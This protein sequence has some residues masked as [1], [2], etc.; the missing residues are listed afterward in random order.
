MFRVNKP[1]AKG[2]SGMTQFGRALAE[3]NIEILCANSSQA[4]GRVE[5]ANRTLQ[6]RL[7]KELRL[8]DVSTIEAGNAFLPGFVESF[9]ERFAVR[10]AKPDDLHRKLGIAASR[11]SDILCHREQRYVGAQLTLSYDRKQIILERNEVSEELAGQYVELYD[12]PDRPL[13]VRW[14]GHL[15]PYR[16]FA[17]DQRVS[18]T[19]IVENKRLG[20]VLRIV[21][22][23][24][25]VHH[26]PT[27]QTNSSKG[28]YQK[29]GRRIYGP[30]Y[31][32][33]APPAEAVEMTS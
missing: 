30:D 31:E 10:A 28:G 29:R 9:N 19:A 1:D 21:K 14:K 32:S 17:K 23:Q 12:F 3:L 6:D 4:K 16:V 33:G 27:V 11:I 22:A 8:A 15:L 24:Q 2:G 13:E 20:H 26:S 7:V 25:D 18:H 5:R